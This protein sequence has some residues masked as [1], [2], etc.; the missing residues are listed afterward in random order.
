M[1]NEDLYKAIGDIDDEYIKKAEILPK[2]K[3]FLTY[4]ICGAIA[5]CV[6]LAV[7]GITILNNTI[8]KTDTDTNTNTP[9]DSGNVQ[10][11]NPLQEFDSLEEMEEYLGYKVPTLDKEIAAYIVIDDEDTRL[12]RIEYSDGST[13]SMADG[14]GDI[15]GIWG[16]SFK[17]S[18]TISGV[19]VNF[20]Q[21]TDV[22][23]V[24]INYA[25]WE[26]DGFTYSYESL[27]IDSDDIQTLIEGRS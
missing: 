23:N 17:S 3:K 7:G 2:K 20:Y 27:L 12:A 18:Q 21:Y 25:L 11:P 4:R 22:D 8:L 5:A 9:P 13:F 24:T 15:S 26:T 16:G 19:E 6:C 10:I 1:N 14:S